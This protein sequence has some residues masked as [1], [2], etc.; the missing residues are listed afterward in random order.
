MVSWFRVCVSYPNIPSGLPPST[1]NSIDIV[2]GT[3]DVV[4][5]TILLNITWEPP[6]PYGEL[7]YYELQLTGELNG[8]ANQTFGG[9]RFFVR[10]NYSDYIPLSRVYNKIL[11]SCNDFA[12][13]TALSNDII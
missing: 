10:H 13:C 9:K 12:K 2:N 6:Y 3:V 5:S 1:I 4:T 11:S 7:E 8:T